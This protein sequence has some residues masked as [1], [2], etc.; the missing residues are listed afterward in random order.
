MTAPSTATL[1]DRIA[2]F[3][4]R[5]RWADL[6]ERRERIRWSVADFVGCTMGATA[7]PEARLATRLARAGEVPVPGLVE[8]FDAPSAA[9][10][11]GTLGA[12]LQLHDVF[13]GGGTHPSSAIVSAAWAA[14]GGRGAGEADFF[15]AVA[16]GYEVGNR[17]AAA[18]YPRQQF[19]GSAPTATAGAI[20]AAVAAG[21]LRGLSA[22]QLAQAIGT[23]AF[24]AP[25]A[26]YQGL[27]DH[28]SAVPIHGGMAAR[29][30]IEAVDLVAAGFAAGRHVLEGDGLPGFV[31]LLH[32]DPTTLTPETWHGE[33]IDMIAYKLMPACFS[34]H[35]IL[36]AG[37]RVLAEAPVAAAK[38]TE[39]V[40]RAAKPMLTLVE[41]GPAPERELYDRLMSARW[42]LASLF[43]Y[44]RYGLANV[45][46]RAR[47]AE[48]ERLARV[49][50]IER[51]P[52]LEAEYPRRIAVEVSVMEAGAAPRTTTYERKLGGG[53]V[54]LAGA[55]GSIN[56]VDAVRLG[57]KFHDLCAFAG[58]SRSEAD[59]LLRPI[60]F[61]PQAN[62][63]E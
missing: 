50:R 33:T 22:A 25:V 43:V 32:G 3:A 13:A 19:A 49:I 40:V 7:L 2:D 63:A 10:V 52:D 16:A 45:A 46:D 11:M 62:A 53:D 5:F 37:Q 21:R 8:R 35:P 17:I 48:V 20:G 1:A 30:G 24:L 58:L 27:R 61:D 29:A 44:G 56:R 60:V 41:T 38:V 39:V 4:A 51:A 18:T 23:A 54:N 14:A 55:T 59:A 34:S 26:C 47:D 42:A 9:L 57:A 28:G 12:M 15:A 6:P 36:E 31:A